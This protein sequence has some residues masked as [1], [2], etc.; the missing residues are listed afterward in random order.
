[1]KTR[2]ISKIATLAL[3]ATLWLLNLITGCSTVSP[4]PVES[5]KAAY[6]SSTPTGYDPNNSGLIE[7]VSDERGKTVGA[8]ITTNARTRWYNLIDAYKLQFKSEYKIDLATAPE[9]KPWT[10]PTITKRDCIDP[11]PTERQLYYMESEYMQY[12]MRL[13]QWS[14]DKRDNDSIWMKIKNGTL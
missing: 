5:K 14:K 4:D 7:Y 2:K 10:K 13:S 8:I 3:L 6:D 1:M 11:I 9:V 12:F